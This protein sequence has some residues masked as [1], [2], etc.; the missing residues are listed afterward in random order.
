[1]RIDGSVWVMT[2]DGT[3]NKYVR[4]VGETFRMIGLE[5]PI[6][7]AADFYTDEDQVKIY[8]LDSGEGRVVV[9]GKDGKYEAQY[10]DEQ[11]KLATQLLVSEK[12][13][14]MWL[15]GGNKIWEVGLK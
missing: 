3:I 7:E 10:R 15:L 9:V 8:I 12:E 2:Q 11:M 14:K 13:G 5:K 1:M 6:A 4:G